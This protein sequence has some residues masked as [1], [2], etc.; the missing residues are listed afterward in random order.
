MNFQAILSNEI[1]PVVQLLNS[2]VYLLDSTPPS[3]I[4]IRLNRST[5]PT[6]FNSQFRQ[7]FLTPLANKGIEEQLK[8]SVRLRSVLRS[9]SEKDNRSVAVLH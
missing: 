8:G 3:L 7:Y 4:R 1:L 5:Q 2:Y 6:L 9:E